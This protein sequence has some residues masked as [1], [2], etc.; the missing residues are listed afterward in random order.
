MAAGCLVIGSATAPVQEVL[1][2]GVN[3][4]LCDFFSPD[5][6]CDRIDEVFEDPDRMA[7]LRAAARATAVADFDLRASALPRWLDLI[8]DLIGGAAP[9]A[10]P[11]IDGPATRNN[12]R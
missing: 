5:A 2:D 12:L 8:G 3:G 1:Q 7:S 9:A 11:P 10:D 4:L 6:L